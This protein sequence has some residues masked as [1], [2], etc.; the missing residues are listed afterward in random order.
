MAITIQMVIGRLVLEKIVS[1][2]E[3]YPQEVVGA[4]EIAIECLSDWDGRYDHPPEIWHKP[5]GS[6][7]WRA[8]KSVAEEHNLTLSEILNQ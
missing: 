8:F 6:S 4:A 1:N 5:E 7:S 3:K 2:P